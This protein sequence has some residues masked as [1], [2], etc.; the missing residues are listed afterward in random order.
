MWNDFSL[1]VLVG[2]AAQLVDGAIGMA[3]GVTATSILL[4]FG[5]APATASAAIHAAEVFTTAASGAAHWRAGNVQWD[6]V[7]RLAIP[8][9][10]GAMAGAALLSVVPGR[11]IQPVVSLYLLC[12]G[13]IILWR[14]L[15]KPKPHSLAR[16]GYGLGLVGGFLDAVGGGGWG[17]MVTTTLLA[18]SA[19]PRFTIGSV[20]AAE[21]FVTTAATA[22]FIPTVGLSLWPTILGLIVGGVLVA[23]VAAMIARHLP[24]RP[25]MVIVGVV[26]IGLSTRNLVVHWW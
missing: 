6:L 8:G 9:V 14:A 1:F 7:R 21:F 10:L 16:P 12:M 11:T 2:A 26:V 15:R 5:T 13:S 17:A 3:Y 23:P 25:I 22:V 20:S 24:A 19:A 18:N 4:S